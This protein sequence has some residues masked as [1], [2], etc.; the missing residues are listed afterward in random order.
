MRFEFAKKPNNFQPK[1]KNLFVNLYLFLCLELKEKKNDFL[2][3]WNLLVSGL[4]SV[5]D[6]ERNENIALR[7]NLHLIN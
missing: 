2:L 4:K 1:T 5:F 7:E 3:F 6:N